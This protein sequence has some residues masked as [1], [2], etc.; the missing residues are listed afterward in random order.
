MYTMQQ[1]AT[2]GTPFNPFSG[3]GQGEAFVGDNV[4]RL[5][6]ALDSNKWNDPRFVLGS[7]IENAGLTLKPNA[8]GI[9][10]FLKDQNSQWSEQTVYNASEV[11]GIAPLEEMLKEA[12]KRLEPLR[13]RVSPEPVRD[14]LRDLD[15]EFVMTPDSPPELKTEHEGDSL[16]VTPMIKADGSDQVIDGRTTPEYVFTPVLGRVFTERVEKSGE[17]F[18][19]NAKSPALVDRGQSVVVHDTKADAY[20]AVM[21]LAK[22]K[23]WESIQLAGKPEHIARGWLEAQLLGITVTN[24]S[25]TEQDLADLESRRASHAKDAVHAPHTHSE[26]PT[27][28]PTRAETQ[29]ASVVSSGQHVGTIVD[30][31]D[32]HAIQSTGRGTY[33]A[34]ELS[35]FD[36]APLVGDSLDIKYRSGRAQV[37]PV[38]SRDQGVGR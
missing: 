19:A 38:K 20:Q 16:S 18:R 27:P 12:K 32:G 4:D 5:F 3:D 30:I 2:S 26:E 14:D 37:A 29:G 23:G 6:A 31:Q 17:Y 24:Y 8:N 22:S 1:F 35:R 28:P 21:E 25:P 33:T 11:E 15:A 10:V 36:K 7:Q 9:P 13:N 34:H